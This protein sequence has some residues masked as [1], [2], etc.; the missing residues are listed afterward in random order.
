MGQDPAHVHE[1]VEGLVQTAVH[2]YRSKLLDLSSRN[3]LVSFRHSERSRS[4]IRIVEEVPELLFSKLEAGRELAFEPLSEPVLIPD[5]E[6][7]PDFE[8]ALG[9]AKREDAEYQEAL[10][11][12]GPSASERQKKKL[13]RKLRDRVRAELGLAPFEPTVDPQARARQIG[14]NPDYDLAR[15]TGQPRRFRNGSI[16]TLF[17]SDN[18]D[19]KLSALRDSARVLLNDAGL[20]A[21]YCAFGFLEYY[22]SST[23]D[24]RRIAPLVFYP[25]ELDRVLQEGEYRYFIRPTNGEIEVNV[26]LAELLRQELSLELPQWQELE[27]ETSPLELFFSNVEKAI[28]KRPEWRLR[29]FVTIGLFTFSTLVMY[30]DLE[31]QKWSATGEPLEKNDLLR[32]LVAG[33]EVRTARFAEDYPIDEVKDRDV[34]IVTDADSSQHSAVIDVLRGKNCVIQ[35][36]PGTGKSQTI[37]NI[38]AAAL[39]A[40]KSV[41][42]IAEKMAALEVVAKRLRA[43][44]LGQFC[45]ELHSTKT[46]KTAL[47]A[48][49]SAR[50]EYRPPKPP[51]QQIQSNLEALDRAKKELIYYVQKTNE[52]AGQTGLTVHEVLVGSAKRETA[53]NRL[54]P[55]FSDAR[56]ANAMNTSQYQRAEMLAAAATLETQLAPL[57]SYGGLK[58]HPWRGFQNVEITDFEA[59]E[60]LSRL[61]LWTDAMESLLEREGTVA[62]LTQ[63]R[64]P[65]DVNALQKLCEVIVELP[66][67]GIGVLPDLLSKLNR[68]HARKALAEINASIEALVSSESAL[69]QYTANPAAAVALGSARLS[70]VMGS[71]EEIGVSNCT[72]AELRELLAG[73]QDSL[74]RLRR[75]QRA[76]E[77]LIK[78]LNLFT[79]NVDDICAATAGADLLCEL[80]REAWFSRSKALLDERKLPLLKA[81]ESTCKDLKSR[82]ERLEPKLDLAALPTP[83][84]LSRYAFAIKTT[85]VI[86]APFNLDCRAGRKIYRFASRHPERKV[87]RL[88][89]AEDLKQCGQYANDEKQFLANQSTRSLCGE[90]FHGLSTPF[91]KLIGLNVW[92]GK[93]TASLSRYGGAGERVRQALFAGA[94]EQ[95]DAVIAEAKTDD[96][97]A[98]KSIT[99]RKG[100]IVSIEA[101][102]EQEAK[103][104]ARVSEAI[105]A[106]KEAEIAAGTELVNLKSVIALIKQIEQ[107]STELEADHR[108]R[109]L[110]P[111]G[112]A[113][114]QATLADLKTTFSYAN[115]LA[116]LPLPSS[117]T[118][119]LFAS[120]QNIKMG[121]EQFT[122]LSMKIG[123]TKQAA[124]RF[125]ELATLDP[126]LWCDKTDLNES[127]IATLVERCKRAADAPS[128]LRDYVSF[129]LAEDDACDKGLG[130]VLKAYLDADA[131][132][133]NLEGAADLV[134][135]RSAAEQVLNDDP[136]LKRH[137]GA[138]HDQLRRQYQRLDREFLQLRQKLLC[139]QL[140]ERQIP[141]GNYLGKVGDLTELA[142]VQHLAGQARPRIAIRELFRRGSKAIQALM[143]CWMMSPMSVAQFLP[144]GAVTFDLVV[145]DE[146]SQIRPE[147]A[148][149]AIVRGRQATVVGDQMQL[150]PTPFFQ[151]LSSDGAAENEDEEAIDVKQ[152]SILEAAAARF[153]PVRRLKW[154]Y[155][156]EHG[157]LISFSNREFYE[158]DLTVFPSTHHDHPHYGVKLVEVGGR[159]N[160]G[161]NEA[162]VNAVVE[163]ALD[164]MGEHVDQSLGIV[165]VNS[166]QADLIRERMD[167]TFAEN[168]R[169]EAY[170]ARWESELESFFVKNL[171]NVQ[172]DERDAIFISTVYGPD[173]SG[174]FY[175]R[176]GPINSEYGHRRLNVLFTRAKKK[177]VL[178]T[179]MKAEEIEDEGKNWGVRALKGYIQFARDGHATLPDEGSKEC[180]SEF[181]RWVMDSLRASGFQTVPQLGFA[182]YR[183]DIA[184]RHPRHPG[185]FLCGIECDGA[186]YHSARS[187]RER[188]RLRQEILERLGWCIYRIWSTDWFRNPSLEMLKLVDYLQKLAARAT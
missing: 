186:A 68:P 130:P 116:E 21:L 1:S 20:N 119:W 23:T 165:A 100:T 41:L 62:D 106:L 111:V 176:F 149:G 127:P 122:T 146:A 168:P 97:L 14:I 70:S 32:T 5:D 137:S 29:R 11:K 30:K 86:F 83:S 136:R 166:K 151:K 55:T 10:I 178:F 45:L 158:G 15:N 187:V 112:M 108:V 174:N 78:I 76:A 81:A 156:S 161:T 164:F 138:T 113:E 142:L 107:K 74:E 135:F 121:Q 129:L 171:E 118:D 160:A 132:Y 188:D 87:S 139:A 43:A 131:D 2:Q 25:V 133:Q 105:A 31:L 36:P 42:F 37:T 148:L 27:G 167:K 33:A 46:T 179:S 125:D 13:E 124:R 3:P 54:P 95:L 170:R 85:N 143:P 102:Q 150:P 99:D 152:E 98:L 104:E 80:D 50:L 61:K 182:G 48:S 117:L 77:V 153:Y 40:G 123:Q 12:L 134:F 73:T 49:L 155:R 44:G 90:D 162:E 109:S 53:R 75:A 9:K 4:H 94:V 6:V 26:A 163:A 8:A 66:P 38:I 72:V 157:S 71:L 51:A 175:Q 177:V 18:L 141:E 56:L 183:I 114:A 184:V 91:D 7:T 39:H 115:L 172:G 59:D 145:M 103:R 16:H 64:L 57:A 185:I 140:A 101:L 84:E 24:E 79:N 147:E 60:L 63:S 58:Q 144:P 93:V 110:L 126:S 96:Y 67:P 82:R 52:P 47:L 89:I 69:K 169:A 34:L 17:F 19:R 173:Q 128:S 92:A 181:E 88:E 120:V 22:V 154:H 180:D 28:S 159:Y 35:G 65:Q